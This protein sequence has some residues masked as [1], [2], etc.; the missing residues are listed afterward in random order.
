MLNEPP[1]RSH[2]VGLDRGRRPVESPAKV[3]A[4]PETEEEEEEEE[5]KEDKEDRRSTESAGLGMPED[6]FLPTALT[7]A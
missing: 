7:W 3:A 5:D 6:S 4:E 1:P 2:E